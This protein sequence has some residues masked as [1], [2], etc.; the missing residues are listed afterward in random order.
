M[1]A[2]EWI[3]SQ[4]GIEPPAEVYC[5]TRDVADG[6][7]SS[8][9]QMLIQQFYDEQAA[10]LAA[11]IT[12]ELTANCFDHNL[13]AWRDIPGCWFSFGKED[14]TV[15][16]TVADRGQGIL[17]SL[18]R[19]YPN[20]ATHRDALIAA[21]TQQISGRA[22]ERRGRGLKFV[23]ASLNGNL[24]GSK[25]ILHSGDAWAAIIAPYDLDAVRQ[26]VEEAPEHLDGTYAK[27]ILSGK[28]STTV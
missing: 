27:L 24:T 18:H 8:L 13:G 21:L 5:P 20:L 19:A 11:A 23:V 14:T 3:Q 17:G 9:Y 15:A 25:F 7:L 10:A 22:P 16:I 12:G 2:K 6:R 28:Q 4:K 26:S 1:D